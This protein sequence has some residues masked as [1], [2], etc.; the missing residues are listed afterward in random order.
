MR[1]K[2]FPTVGGSLG[3]LS[4]KAV[5]AFGGAEPE[6]AVVL[7][8]GVEVV[9]PAAAAAGVTAAVVALGVVPL[10][11]PVPFVPFVPELEAAV[12]GA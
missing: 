4:F 3:F 5:D 11:L 12:L 8:A 1:K 6:R 10:A 2:T 9:R 7:L